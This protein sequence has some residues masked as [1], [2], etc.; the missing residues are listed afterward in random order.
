MAKSAS[1]CGIQIRRSKVPASFYAA[2]NDVERGRAVGLAKKY[3]VWFLATY[4]GKN[5]VNCSSVATGVQYSAR[6]TVGA[7]VEF[8]QY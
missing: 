8:V 6:F 2:H 3:G 5:W 7:P 1:N 4:D